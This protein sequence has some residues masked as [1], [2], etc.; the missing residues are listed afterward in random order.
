MNKNKKKKNYFLD[1]NKASTIKE[2]AVKT[3]K[4]MNWT[5][6]LSYWHFNL[7][8]PQKMFTLNIFAFNW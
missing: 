4:L 6:K 8:S 5:Q 7:E 3:I 2:S 1:L